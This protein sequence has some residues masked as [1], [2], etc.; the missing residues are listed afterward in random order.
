[1]SNGQSIYAVFRYTDPKAGIAWLKSAL[2]FAEHVVYENEDG[3]IAHA[4][5]QLNGNLIMLGGGKS[6]SGGCY[7]ALGSRE[8]ID[9]C[10]ER[11]KAAGARIQRELCDTDYESHEFSVSDPE[12]H[13]WSFGTYA[14]QAGERA[15][16]SA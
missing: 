15:A 1:M 12:G 13:V 5:L 14:P 3:S 8:A 11:A 10:Y 9:A 4:E 2:G 6:Q 7:I 16:A